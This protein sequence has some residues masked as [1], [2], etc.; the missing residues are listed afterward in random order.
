LT[1]RAVVEKVAAIF[2]IENVEAFLDELKK[3]T[4]ANDAKKSADAAAEMQAAM[5]QLQKPK[6]DGSSGTAADPTGAPAAGKPGSGAE[7]PGAAP[8][9][10]KV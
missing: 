4:D 5:K 6:A 2:G 3:E 1:V 8:P 10:G 9:A 7:R